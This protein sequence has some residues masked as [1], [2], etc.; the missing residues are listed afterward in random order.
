MEIAVIVPALNEEITIKKVVLDF[1]KELPDSTIYVFDNGSQDK[2]AALAAEAGAKVMKVPRRG[3]GFAMQEAFEKV[4]ADYYVIVD[5][6]DTY[7]AH[8]VHKLLQPVRAGEADM[9]VGNRMGHFTKEEKRIIHSIGNRLI[10]WA[11]KICFPTKIK[12]MLSGYRVLS[13]QAVMSLSLIS[14]GFAIETELTIKALEEGLRIREV[15]IIYRKRPDGSKSKLDTFADGMYI[16][17]T[18]LSLFRDYR[19]M[20]FFLLFSILPFSIAVG[21]GYNVA[22]EFFTTGAVTLYG[23]LMLSILF[24]ILAFLLLMM[25]FLASSVHASTREMM[26]ILK[27]RY[28][29]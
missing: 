4:E 13:K 25:G 24:I 7:E 3:K 10:L 16:T 15:P 28:R 11:L 17:T 22:V 14:A 18:I 6:D 19:P 12:D 23:S 21:F 9:T 20:Q 2:T 27:R 29:K 26:H 5:A 1:K 8:D